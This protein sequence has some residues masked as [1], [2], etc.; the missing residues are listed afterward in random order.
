MTPHTSIKYDPSAQGFFQ[1]PYPQFASLREQSSVHRTDQGVYLVLRHNEAHDYLS[2]P[3]TSVMLKSLAGNAVVDPWQPAAQSVINQDPPNHTRLRR[4]LLQAFTS[5][6]VA[7][8]RPMIQSTFDTLRASLEANGGGDFVKDVAF[9]MPFSVICKML[10]VPAENA[11]VVCDASLTVTKAIIDLEHSPETLVAARSAYDDMTEYFLKLIADKRRKPDEHIL[12][13]LIAAEEDGSRLSTE[14]LV[15]QIALIYIGGFDSVISMLGSGLLLLLKNPEQRRIWLS[16]PSLDVN[17]IEE[18]VRFE[19]PVLFGGR[20]ITTE[21]IEIGGTAIPAGAVV[22]ACAASA[23]RDP[24]FWGPDAES[25]RIGRREASRNLT[26]GGGIHRCLGNVLAR[27]QG[28]IV[29]RDMIR[30]FPDMHVLGHEP[31]WKQG[32]HQRSLEAL[33]LALNA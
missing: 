30:F 32:T 19:P 9:P 4:L 17:A 20:R 13:A 22:L 29:L 3:G 26:F 21:S 24:R 10:G 2:L 15:D 27:T 1:N 12:S 7:A 23:N 31:V 6:A 8:L 18:I 5:K 28:Q 25:F 11:E 14:E 16:D 33:P